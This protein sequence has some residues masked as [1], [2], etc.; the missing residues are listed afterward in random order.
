MSSDI[1]YILMVLFPL[2]KN[3]FFKQEVRK[4]IS[5]LCVFQDMRDSLNIHESHMP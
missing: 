4:R 3:F 2:S 1:D 5:Q